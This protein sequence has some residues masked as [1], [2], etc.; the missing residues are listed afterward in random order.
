MD[1]FPLLKYDEVDGGTL[2]GYPFVTSAAATVGN[3]ERAYFAADWA[4]AWIGLEPSFVTVGARVAPPTAA[5]A[6]QADLVITASMPLDFALR[7]P[8]PPPLLHPR[9]PGRSPDGRLTSSRGAVDS[10]LGPH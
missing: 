4:D 2:L 7:R 1:T 6:A 3:Q 10:H 8:P 9:L 5:G